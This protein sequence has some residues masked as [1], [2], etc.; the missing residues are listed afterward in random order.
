MSTTMR[1]HFWAMVIGVAVMLGTGGAALHHADKQ[2]DSWVNSIKP[3]N[4]AK[5]Q[6]LVAPAQ[7]AHHTKRMPF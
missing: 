6:N 2:F 5:T 7:T 1:I 3:R 4:A